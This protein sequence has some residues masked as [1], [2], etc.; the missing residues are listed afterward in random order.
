MEE[1]K[2]I[3]TGGNAMTPKI[4]VVDDEREVAQ[5]A[6]IYLEKA[7][8]EVLLAHNGAAAR[9]L[10]DENRLS[11]AILDIM[12]PDTD[13]F[14][15]CRYIRERAVYPIIMLTARVEDVDKI[16]GLTIGADDYMTKPFNPLELVARV[17]TQLRRYLHYNALENEAQRTEREEEISIRALYLNRRDH[18]CELNGKPT[19]LTRLEF[20]ILWYLAGRRGEVVESE[21]LFQAVWGDRFYEAG[22]NTVMTH[23]ARI[24]EKLHEQPRHPKYIKTVWGV[25]YT[26][27][28]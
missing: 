18:R 27:E 16:R 23:I 3:G 12:L 13:G 7:G 24:R 25:G 5:L 20:D 15:L 26:I 28:D 2:A 17:K 14:E 8:Y 19:H 22:N 21:Q 11:L 6:A 1:M 4:L 9:R 10:I